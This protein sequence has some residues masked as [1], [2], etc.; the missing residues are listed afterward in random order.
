MSINYVKHI[1]ITLS[2]LRTETLILIITVKNPE[3]GTVV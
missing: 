1:H 3:L 2:S